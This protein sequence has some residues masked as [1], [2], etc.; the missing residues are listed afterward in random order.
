MIIFQTAIKKHQYLNQYKYNRNYR[1][2]KNSFI[3]Y[4]TLDMLAKILLNLNQ[5][6]F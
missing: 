3:K 2:Y 4:F 1:I 6:F 5:S